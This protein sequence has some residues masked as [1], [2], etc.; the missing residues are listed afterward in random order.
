MAHSRNVIVIDGRHSGYTRW[1]FSDRVHL[2]RYGAV[3]FSTD[4]ASVVGR[5]LSRPAMV[6]RWNV[7]PKCRCLEPSVPVEDLAQSLSV[8]K[9]QEVR[10]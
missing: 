5:S 3:A 6:A 8:L 7:L 2:D 4:V 9:S 10:R 1:G